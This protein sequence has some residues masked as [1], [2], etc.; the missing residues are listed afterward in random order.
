ME[1]KST[2]E[3]NGKKYFMDIIFKHEDYLNYPYVGGYYI[4]GVPL[5]ETI[6][7]NGEIVTYKQY[8]YEKIELLIEYDKPDDQGL[9]VAQKVADK[10]IDGIIAQIEQDKREEQ[11]KEENKR[12]DIEETL[13]RANNE[14]EG[15]LNGKN[16][17]NNIS[18][19][20]DLDFFNNDMFDF[21][22]MI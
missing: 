21:N 18:N 16:K 9:L 14:L 2:I 8:A 6:D 7:V 11:I 13:D 1:R 10:H 19:I 3:R 4:M 5:A 17:D 22:S 12:I 15:L 20:F